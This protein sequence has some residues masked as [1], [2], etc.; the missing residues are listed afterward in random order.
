MASGFTTATRNSI[1]TGLFKTDA[2]VYGACCDG[3][4]TDTGDMSGQ[5]IAAS[6]DYARTACVFN[7][8]AAAGSIANTTALEFPA[9][10]GG[11][12][13]TISHLAICSAD[14]EAAD[15]AIASGSLTVSKLIEDGDQ[16][17]FAIGAITIAIAA[18]A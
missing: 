4:P 8:D 13:G 10:N 2:P 15:D 1:L 16:L 6:F 17:V 11:S 3:D 14:V 5:E 12:H 18:Q 7:D 9:A